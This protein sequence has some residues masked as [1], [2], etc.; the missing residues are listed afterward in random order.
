MKFDSTPPLLSPTIHGL[1]WVVC[2]TAEVEIRDDAKG[3]QWDSGQEI[4]QATLILEY[5]CLNTIFLLILM[6]AL[7]L[8][9]VESSVPLPPSPT[10]QSFPL[11]HPP[12]LYNTAQHLSFSEP[13]KA[14]QLHSTPQH[15]IVSPSMFNSR[16]CSVI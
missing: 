7:G 3:V 14:F 6:C 10:F 16:C 13:Q 8:C 5:C 4:V 11:S 12:K 9:P 1:L 15:K 2:H